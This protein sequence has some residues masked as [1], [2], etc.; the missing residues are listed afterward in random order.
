MKIDQSDIEEQL[1]AFELPKVS[2]AGVRNLLV[3]FTTSECITVGAFYIVNTRINNVYMCFA[4]TLV[5]RY[6]KCI[7]N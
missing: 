4:D 2:E 7:S 3:G 5:G 1:P 6:E